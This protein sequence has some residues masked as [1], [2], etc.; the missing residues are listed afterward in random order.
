MT[1]PSRRSPSASIALHGNN[2][3]FVVWFL[4]HLEVSLF[5]GRYG[6]VDPDGIKREY[7]YETGIKCDPNNRNH[8]DEEE[9]DGYIDYQENKMILPNGVKIDIN[10]KNKARRLP[11]GSPVPRYEN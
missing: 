1:D 3:H 4:L 6:Y 11:A 9:L 5:S 7:N 2:C 8:G 10:T